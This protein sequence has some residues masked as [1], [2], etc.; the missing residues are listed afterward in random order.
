MR[1][2][3]FM[4]CII[5]GE[6]GKEYRSGAV[7]RK[8]FSVDVQTIKT[9]RGGRIDVPVV[10]LKSGRIKT[11]KLNEVLRGSAENAVMEQGLCLPDEWGI[12]PV[13][14]Q[15]ISYLYLKSAVEFWLSSSNIPLRD[16]TATLIDLR[17]VYLDLANIMA[18][19]CALLKVVTLR[20]QEYTLL[21][22]EITSDYGG[23]LQI[24]D[25]LSRPND[26]M[27]LV[28]PKGFG[29]DMGGQLIVPVVT[30]EPDQFRNARVL[31]GF[32]Q[33]KLECYNDIFP[34]SIDSLQF[35]A[36]L[37]RFIFPA[38]SR[39]FLPDQCRLDNRPVTL[40]NILETEFSL[41]SRPGF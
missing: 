19:H 35:A 14:T 10:H 6:K 8:G 32:S 28:S 30:L 12:R 9:S 37:E 18:K 33:S 26:G 4:F 1:Q 39:C 13:D 7:F 25:V 16:R 3:V 23:V 2:G 40:Q 15:R 36:A 22:E 41:D 29:V 27:M 38:E 11:K 34:D 21:A 20:K 17:G 31:H 24:T 5:T